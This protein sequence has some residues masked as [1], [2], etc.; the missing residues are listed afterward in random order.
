MVESHSL[1]NQ[2]LNDFQTLTRQLEG[3]IE[4]FARDE[5]EGVDLGPLSARKRC[6]ARGRG[7]R[8]TGLAKYQ[9]A[10]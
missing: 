8:R 7:S 4:A 10:A 9:R 1:L 3:A 5:R 2:V 6:G